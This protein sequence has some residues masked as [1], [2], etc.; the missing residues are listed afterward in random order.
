MLRYIPT[1]ASAGIALTEALWHL[2]CPPGEGST[3]GFGTVVTALDDSLWLEIDDAAVVHVH[4]EAILD[5]IADILRPWI[6]DGYLPADTNEGLAAFVEAKRGQDLTVYEAF[7]Q[8]FKDMSMTTQQMIAA[9]KLA[10]PD[11]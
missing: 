10:N 9:G 11:V 3:T 4:A 2:H 6:D 8:L 1:S 5:N 7:P